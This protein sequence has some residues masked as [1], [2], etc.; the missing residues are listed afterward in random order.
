MPLL[1]RRALGLGLVVHRAHVLEL[2]GRGGGGLVEAR[3]RGELL[4]EL[5][6]HLH[7]RARVCAGVRACVCVCLSV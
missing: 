3:A 2:G 1:Q 5:P 4:V 7:G 6:V